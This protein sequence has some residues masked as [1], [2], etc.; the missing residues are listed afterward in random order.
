V[1][2]PLSPRRVWQTAHMHCTPLVRRLALSLALGVAGWP[3]AAAPEAQLDLQ[4]SLCTSPAEVQRALALEQRGAPFEVWLF[5]NPALELLNH[6]LR[7]RLR[8]AGTKSKELTLKL[9]AQDCS[10]LPPLPRGEGKCEYDSHDTTISGS[11]SL[12]RK[13]AAGRANALLAGQLALADVLSPTQLSALRNAPGGWPLPADLR[14]LGPT[15][16]SAYLSGD[17]AYQ[18]DISELPGGE[19][20]IEISRK[21]ALSDAEPA[22]R[23]FEADLAKSGVD[24]CAD[25]SAQAVNK[26]RALLRLP[27]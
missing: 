5:D 6:G 23:R 21:V 3:A 17:K 26:L 11:L 7:I 13:L 4:F 8:G 25:Q 19:R 15:R 14:A 16:V 10:K 20:F 22:R 27:R 2:Q 24:V 12:T 1:S 9:A 18:V